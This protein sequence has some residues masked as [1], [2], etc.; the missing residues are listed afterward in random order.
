LAAT[1][2]L[3]LCRKHAVVLPLFDTRLLT[4]Q[5]LLLAGTVFAATYA[6]LA[7]MLRTRFLTLR[8]AQHQARYAGVA[9]IASLTL[10]SYVTV[11]SVPLRVGLLAGAFLILLVGTRDEQQPLTPPVQ[12]VW[13]IVIATVVV[14]WGWTIPYVSH[15]WQEGIINLQWYALGSLWLPGSVLA[16]GWLLLLMNAINWLDGV[17]GLASGVGTVAL[18]TLAVVSLLPSTQHEPTLKLALIGAGAV[19]ALF[20]WSFPPAR[21]FLGTSGSWF[22]GL[23]IGLV[24]M[25]GGGKVVTTLLVL[26]L[27]V[28]DFLAVIIQRV[29]HKQA[30]W[31][32]DT[33]HHVHHRLQ[34]WGLSA[35]SITLLA[36]V[37]T[38]AC[39][40][41]AIVL[42]TAQKIVALGVAAGMLAAVLC[43]HVWLS[44]PRRIKVSSR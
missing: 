2:H 18:L 6:A 32:G 21:V 7:I 10:A 29:W 1:Y 25:I 36:M 40:V 35:R 14:A 34:Q 30:P 44:S 42:Q 27:P 23:Y 19:A 41:A 17:D 31:R 38:G 11:D 22:L 33:V 26:A 16:I 13:Q 28:L 5:L 39:G 20:L 43:I 37:V 8:A 12:L 3:T 4:P 24:A 15:P 9:L